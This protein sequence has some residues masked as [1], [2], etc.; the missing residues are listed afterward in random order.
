MWELLTT[1]A[2]QPTGWGGT[3]TGTEEEKI[4]PSGEAVKSR[5]DKTKLTRQENREAVPGERP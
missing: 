4:P 1:T 2:L 5:N 3:Q